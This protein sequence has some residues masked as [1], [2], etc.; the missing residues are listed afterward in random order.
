MSDQNS[1]NFIF[2]TN[3]N[4]NNN[5]LTKTK[6][7]KNASNGTSNLINNL[8]PLNSPSTVKDNTKNNNN[9]DLIL[10]QNSDNS[11]IFGSPT[12]SETIYEFGSHFENSS[13]VVSEKVQNLASQIYHELQKILTRYNDDEEAVSGLMQLIINV[14]ESLDLALIENQQLQV[15]LELCKDD[16]EQLVQAFEKEKQSKKKIEQRLFENEFTAEEE[17]QHFQQR[18]DSLANIV[19]MLELKAKNSSDHSTR[20]EEKETEMK[21]EYS[22]LHER[23]TE[24]LRS[25]CD[26]M[27]RVKIMFGTDESTNSNTNNNNAINQ[28][29]ENLASVFKSNLQRL[30]TNEDNLDNYDLTGIDADDHLDH[31][32]NTTLALSSDMNRAGESLSNSLA[33]QAWI[34]TE[35]SYD[36]TTTIIEDVEELQKDKFS[37][38]NNNRD[39][40]LTENFFGMEKEIENL[41]TENQELLATKNA[42]NIV[43][44]DL[45][46]K[47][48]ELQGDLAM[49]KN[50]IQQREAVQDRLKSR[51][52]QMEDEIK[53][54]K[55]ELEETKQ[56]LAAI[57]E[58]D[59]EGVPMAQRKRFTRVE[60]SRVLM[61]RNSYKEKYF[62]LQEALKWSELSRATKTED[63]RSNIWKFFS[64]FFNP[65]PT[66]GIISGSQSVQNAQPAIRYLNNPSG[67]PALEAMRRRARLQQNGGDLELMLDSD[68]T[69]ER[70]RAMKNLKAHVTR[71][72]SG[73]RIQAYGWSIAGSPTSSSQSQSE[74]TKQ[75][76]NSATVPVP[77]YC[78][79]LGGEDIGMKIWCSSAVDLSGGEAGFPD[80][81]NSETKSNENQ[82]NALADL[83]SEIDEVI[84]E[85]T[86][87]ADQQYSNF[88]WI[89]SVS[90]S[91][92]KATIVNIRSNPGEVL[93]SFFIK[94]HLLCIVSI[95]GAK[96]NDMIGKRD[97]I[98]NEDSPELC[99][100]QRKEKPLNDISTSITFS[101]PVPSIQSDVS[102][103]YGI[104]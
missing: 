56:K 1:T 70:T 58:D 21:K 12:N 68:L 93:D 31:H 32:Q 82:K 81:N 34:E 42:L 26:L 16:N 19:K 28:T 47:V 23:Y 11:P 49:C 24:L 65:S 78:R 98:I 85:Q 7:I 97:I 36:D 89:C 8:P 77:I 104:K 33:R 29:K 74:N 18:I 30:T 72:G 14:L 39:Q 92:S 91:K 71:S 69:S 61:E 37:S 46:A 51:I 10:S 54:N 87:T 55:D 57:K 50:E 80:T 3:S 73:D 83:E 100:D 22:K 43:K 88:V 25:H 96:N 79:P 27:E 62:E 13:H 45:I 9:N 17:K 95:P 6:D 20:L 5:L 64:S 2:G 63:K 59:E 4:N 53:K 75:I 86:V 35:M 66:T 103:N 38:T 102:N 99:L 90:H 76:M 48:D 40:S 94:T 101:S 52:N 60:M 67:T 44:D 15:D 41:I 84:K